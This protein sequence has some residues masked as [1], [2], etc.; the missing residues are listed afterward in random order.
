M[1][2]DA[3]AFAPLS[4]QEAEQAATPKKGKVE[5]VPIVPV[6]DDAPDCTFKIPALG[7]SPKRLWEYRDGAGRLLG[8][9]ARFEYME[10]DRL[11][12]QVMPVT[13]C[14]EGDKRVWRSKAFPAPR[15]LYGLD[16]LAARQFAPVVIAEGAKSADAVG[17]L[18][19][20]HV[21]MSWQGGSNAISQSHWSSLKDRDVLIWPDRDRHTEMSGEEKPYSDQPGTIAAENIIARLKGVAASIRVL[22][23]SDVD[24]TDGWDA[25]DA[26]ADGWT[27]EAT[28]AFVARFAVE[29]DQAAPGTVMPFGFEDGVEG[30]FHLDGDKRVRIAGRLKVLAKTRDTNG[31]SWGLLLEWRDHD[32]RLHRWAMPMSTLSGDG[33][34]IREALLERGLFV[35]TDPKA[36]SKLMDFFST[37]DTAYRARAVGKVGWSASAFALPEITIGDTPED[38]V[39]YQQAD[40]AVHQYQS[41]GTLEEWH[42]NVARLAIGNSRLVFMMSSALVGPVLLPACEEGGGVNVVGSSS[43]GKST[44]MRA[45][46][47]FWGPPAFIRQWR[48]TSNG[49]ES[50]AAQHN[51]TFLC[52]DELSQV[53]P[54]EAG[55]IA[56]MLGNGQGKS[57]ASRSG[58]SRAATTWKL[59]YLST[60]EVGLSEIMREGRQGRSP[61]AGQEVR[62]LDVPADAGK[63]MG[64]FE[65]IHGAA[66]P[67]AFARQI[68]TAATTF[69]GTASIEFLT[70][71]ASIRDSIGD[72]ISATIADFV[73]THVPIGADGQVMR[74]ARRFGLVAAAGE[75]G[76]ALGILPWPRREAFDAAAVMFLA[77][78]ER[79]GGVG[80]AEDRNIL[81]QVRAFFEAHGETRFSPSN[82]EDTNARP[83]INRAGFYSSSYNSD[84]DQVREYWVLREAFKE[85]CHG[86]DESAV[87]RVLKDVGAL[88]LS[89]EGKPQTAKRLPEM[90]LQKVYVIGPEI[91]GD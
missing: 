29:V 21:A 41:A 45:A 64:L 24:C 35:S 27:S 13:F 78:V 83:V 61:M 38:R 22:D 53:D 52:L 4:E 88:K 54:R 7:G 74:A 68:T 62:I 65:N 81:A 60:G 75:L 39:I 6:P 14:Q 31:Q 76:I 1:I 51:E 91:F 37:V 84:N 12:K 70:K 50:V 8:Y 42:E 58:G 2:L 10:G 67:D 30:L 19:P 73:A 40:G 77:W 90:G 69:Y 20:D 63:G 82:E 71:L 86:H 16:R 36:R 5:R 28:Q 59:M 23:L 34:M 72:A 85:I 3:E 56:Y 49:L 17:E 18:L 47:S 25:A 57:R 87:R 33:T 55:P 80:A 32:G 9:D 44:G 46:A 43:T 66:S 89:S 48:A 11:A 79:R 26:L 15:P